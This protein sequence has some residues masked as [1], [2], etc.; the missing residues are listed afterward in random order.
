MTMSLT[1]VNTSNWDGEEYIVKDANGGWADG[2]RAELV[3]TIKPGESMVVYP[4]KDGGTNYK[5]EAVQYDERPFYIPEMQGVRLGKKQ[6][7]PK[8]TVTFE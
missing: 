4:D 5:V 6:V 3:K 2:K 7:Q 8:L 1:L